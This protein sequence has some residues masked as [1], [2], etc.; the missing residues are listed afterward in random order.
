MGITTKMIEITLQKFKKSRKEKIPFLQL[1]YEVYC[2][3]DVDSSGR[4]VP[5]KTQLF[6]WILQ[7]MLFLICFKISFGF[8]LCKHHS[9]N[10]SNFELLNK[11]TK[12]NFD[13]IFL[14]FFSLI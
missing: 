7:I 5:G 6:L 13:R 3:Y 12:H 9:E 10:L 11:T 1:E 8:K 14:S 4:E 2:S